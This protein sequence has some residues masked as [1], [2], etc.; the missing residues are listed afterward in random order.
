MNYCDCDRNIIR[1]FTLS[2]N[3]EPVQMMCVAVSEQ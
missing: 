3:G 1:E 2:I